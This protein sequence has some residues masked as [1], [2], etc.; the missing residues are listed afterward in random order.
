MFSFKNI[1]ASQMGVRCLP[2]TK[3]IKAEQ[4]NY[5]FEI[6]GRDGNYDQTDGSYNSGTIT[7]PLVYMQTQSPVQLRSIAEWLSGSGQ[8]IFDSEPDKAYAATAYTE[9][10]ANENVFEETFSVEFKVFPFAESLAYAQEQAFGVSLPYSVTP[11]VSGTQSTPCIIRIVAQS[12]IDNLIIT[13]I[14]TE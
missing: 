3:T 5:V 7:I 6:P 10:T 8:L 1:H 11:D 13:K 4:R 2:Y 9:I 12:D 14:L